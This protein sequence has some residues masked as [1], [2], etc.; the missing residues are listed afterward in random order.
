M[1]L[2]S[3]K[4]KG[5]KDGNSSQGAQSP[6][7]EETMCLRAGPPP[8]MLFSEVPSGSSRGHSGP[9]GRRLPSP[10]SARCPHPT[11][12]HGADAHPLWIDCRGCPSQHQGAM[13]TYPTALGVWGSP[14]T[15]WFCS[16][17]VRGAGHPLCHQAP[18]ISRADLWACTCLGC[19]GALRSPLGEEAPPS[20]GHTCS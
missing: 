8:R 9:S 13:P 2:P 3:Q 7:K 5:V 19:S 20:R 4:E 15:S 14:D 10:N 6:R 1:L 18:A 17:V 16:P 11:V 12:T